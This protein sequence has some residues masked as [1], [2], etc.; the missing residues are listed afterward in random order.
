MGIRHCLYSVKEASDPGETM[1]RTAIW[2]LLVVLGCATPRIGT[3]DDVYARQAEEH[4]ARA[5]EFAD[6]YEIKDYT[7]LGITMFVPFKK[8]GFKL[9]RA[10]PGVGEIWSASTE[11]YPFPQRTVKLDASGSVVEI[12]A[13]QFFTSESDAQTFLNDT[14]LA[15]RDRFPY[16]IEHDETETSYTVLFS[17]R[18]EF[19]SW[20]AHHWDV[21]HAEYLQRDRSRGYKTAF[22]YNMN[23]MPNDR[24]LMV[25]LSRHRSEQG[26][27]GVLIMVVGRES[28]ALEHAEREERSK[29]LQQGIF[30]H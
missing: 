6:R 11:Q 9:K 26:I 20:Y 25:G 28:V 22:V 19:L 7:F 14:Y 17:P 5:V 3:P 1:R 2:P 23:R 27:H 18:T 13:V 30:G 29:S 16:M 15:M 4:H 8:E 12:S 24:L 10:Y 21:R